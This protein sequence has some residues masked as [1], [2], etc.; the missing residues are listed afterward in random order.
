MY[1]CNFPFFLLFYYTKYTSSHVCINQIVTAR[2]VNE[3]EQENYC[4]L[5]TKTEM[6]I[7]KRERE[8]DKCRLRI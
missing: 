8:S 3:A 2:P 5:M 7:S 6:L 1:I 4:S